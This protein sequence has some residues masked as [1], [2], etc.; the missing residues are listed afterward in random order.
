MNAADQA[1][2]IQKYAMALL[3]RGAPT[4]EVVDAL[5]VEADAWL[6]AGY[7]E[8]ATHAVRHAQKVLVHGE[9]LIVDDFIV[10]SDTFLISIIG[11]FC[12][13]CGAAWPADFTS[14]QSSWM[15]HDHCIAR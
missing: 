13:Y 11:K 1:A 4:A 6:I 9:P 5:L 14:A 12:T 8:A 3:K 7:G 10:D 15:H 2:E